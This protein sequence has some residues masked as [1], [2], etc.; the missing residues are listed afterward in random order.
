MKKKNYILAITA[1]LGL[2]VL[3]TLALS[4]SAP[5][6]SEA[7][8]S[9]TTLD[10]VAGIVLS[11]PDTKSLDGEND[12]VQV[13]FDVDQV[14]GDTSIV[15]TISAW[16]A[17][18]GGDP[19]G[20]IIKAGTSDATFKYTVTFESSSAQTEITDGVITTIAS[21]EDLTIEITTETGKGKIT[22]LT[23]E[24]TDDG[25]LFGYGVIVFCFLV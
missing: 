3:S 18:G 9:D 25:S 16:D 11:A 24:F 12:N 2:A 23:V 21:G 6:I 14:T 20:A 7:L 17:A 4:I 22:D 1:L 13:S 8:T 5:D 15:F 19:T 10:Y